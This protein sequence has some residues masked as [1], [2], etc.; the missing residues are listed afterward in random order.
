MSNN[1]LSSNPNDDESALTDEDLDGVV[2]GRSTTC[3][4]G[5]T[6]AHE[7]FDPPGQTVTKKTCPGPGGVVM[8]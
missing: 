8:Y 7:Y 1:P 5:Q 4:H 3:T 2:G 6:A